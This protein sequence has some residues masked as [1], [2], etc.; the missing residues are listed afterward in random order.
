MQAKSKINSFT[1][2]ELK[3]MNE[4]INYLTELRPWPGL[5]SYTLS[6]NNFFLGRTQE[7]SDLEKK[8]IS[9]SLIC[10]YGPS[11][12]GKTSLLQAGVSEKISAKGFFSVFIRLNHHNQNYIHQTIQTVYD[13]IKLNNIELEELSDSVFDDDESLWEFF[14][15]NVFWDSRNRLIKP[16]LIFDQFEE[17]FTLTDFGSNA[18]D[19]IRE[20]GE[21]AENVVPE[22]VQYYLRESNQK[23][24]INYE[25]SDY[26][27]ILSIREDFLGQLEMATEC[28]PAFRR[29][30]FPIKA[31]NGFQA[32]EIINKP[33]EGI[34]EDNVDIAIL[35]SISPLKKKGN[36]EI[37]LS[38]RIVEPA[39][40]SL[41]CSEL[42]EQRI[43]ENKEKITIGQVICN[44]GNIINNFYFKC[45]N[46]VSEDTAKYLEDK[47]LTESGYRNPVAL[48]DMLIALVPREDIDI[49]I[50]QR[51]I[52]IEER[53]NILW[54]E[55]SHD[56]LAKSAFT[57]RNN[58]RFEFEIAKEKKL[59][60]ELNANFHIIKNI[61]IGI[62]IISIV[63]FFTISI[64]YLM[65]I[66][67]NYLADFSDHASPFSYVL[68]L[69]FSYLFRINLSFLML[70]N[71][72]KA[73]QSWFIFIS[74]L[75]LSTIFV[76]NKIFEILKIGWFD[77]LVDLFGRLRIIHDQHDRYLIFFI[78]GSFLF[79]TLAFPF[80]YFLGRKIFRK[81][82]KNDTSW[83]S[84]FSL[85]C[86]FKNLKNKSILNIAL[87]W[88]LIIASM[89]LCYHYN[90][91]IVSIIGIPLSLASIYLLMNIKNPF[92]K[93]KLLYKSKRHIGFPIIAFI[94]LLSL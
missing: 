2:K 75:I 49:L 14:H 35:D 28:I 58:R 86:I 84:V 52:R 88:I 61:F 43:T 70:N 38:H 4:N 63:L 77:S 16:L 45:I 68:L 69:C 13:T 31:L 85:L 72:K 71:E 62:D 76:N 51:L 46:S 6:N 42:N 81:S 56:I 7:I 40:L 25:S 44:S 60:K 10:L 48:E 12:V 15:R 50:N 37:N 34:I 54:V 93:Q 17:I 65:E 23:L 8:I 78:C 74:I 64:R 59:T 67:F 47:L 29:N 73:L 5:A 53:N 18:K 21:L 33:G 92:A 9:E 24:K 30:R 20:L 3:T 57:N 91:V 19:L 26:R 39:L 83:I 55:F 90:N 11:G 27:L 22:K 36:I 32:L 89:Y 87:V 82:S 1:Q 94:I 80:I 79:S 66:E 41:F